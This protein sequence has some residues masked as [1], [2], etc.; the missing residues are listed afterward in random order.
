MCYNI[1]RKKRGKGE[2]NIM[3]KV[4][5][6]K[7]GLKPINEVKTINIGEVEVEVKQYLPLEEKIGLIELV[8]QNSIEYNFINPLKVEK[9]FNLF[10]VYKYTNINFTDKMK[11]DEDALYDLLETHGVIDAVA[12]AAQED[13]LYL[14][15]KCE[16]FLDKL[17]NQQNSVY[18]IVSRLINDIPDN[19]ARALEMV[20]EL[21]LEKVGKTLSMISEVGGDKAAVTESLMGQK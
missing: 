3:A 19:M 8:A 1:N 6:T 9:F 18:G 11:E 2:I 13:Y 5:F 14:F 17:Q 21:D 16:E 12:Q 7:L 20:S 15:E 4:S 10:F